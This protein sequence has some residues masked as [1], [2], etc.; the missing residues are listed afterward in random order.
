MFVQI[1]RD[2]GNVIVMFGYTN[3]IELTVYATSKYRGAAR[4]LSQRGA[5]YH[6]REKDFKASFLAHIRYVEIKEKYMVLVAN[7]SRE[8]RRK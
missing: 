4:S 6:I 1:S 2:R 3:K 5:K 8:G 7:C